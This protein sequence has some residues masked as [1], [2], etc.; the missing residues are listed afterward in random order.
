M[1]KCDGCVHY[2][3]VLWKEPKMGCLKGIPSRLVEESPVDGARLAIHL[4]F[5]F[6]RVFDKVEQGC[7]SPQYS[8]HRY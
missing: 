6:Q 5:G 7:D 2:R 4:G 8:V 1:A 3:R